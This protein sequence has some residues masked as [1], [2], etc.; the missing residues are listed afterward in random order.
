MAKI[1][2]CEDEKRIQKLIKAMLA[3]SP[4][5]IFIASDGIE[6][7]E[8]IERERPD[9]VFADVSMPDCDGVQLTDAVKSRPHIAQIPIIFLT[10]FAQQSEKDEAFRHGV[11]DYLTK[12]FT[13]AELLGKIEEFLAGGK[14]ETSSTSSQTSGQEVQ[15]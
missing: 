13:V 5:D 6:G 12:P 7:L 14:N 15:G 10:A 2:F 11:S 8:L 3:G 9:L 4:Y 1:V